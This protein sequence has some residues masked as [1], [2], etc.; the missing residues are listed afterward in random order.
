MGNTNPGVDLLA[1]KFKLP[2]MELEFPKIKLK[3]P[4]MELELNFN[5][6]VLARPYIGVFASLNWGFAS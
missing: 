4:K 1:I 5:L 3:F 2:K 6:R